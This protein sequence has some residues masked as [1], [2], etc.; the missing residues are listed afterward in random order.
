[1]DYVIELN[2]ETWLPTR[3]QGK[4]ERLDSDEGRFA[5]K[6]ASDAL[7]RELLW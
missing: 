4:A 2:S 1:M 7:L 3:H 5:L 6:R